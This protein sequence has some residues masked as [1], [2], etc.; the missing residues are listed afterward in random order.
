M[1]S[2]LP[3]VQGNAN[4]PSP[5]A[6]VLRGPSFSPA[7]TGPRC[8]Q[9]GCKSGRPLAGVWFLQPCTLICNKICYLVSP[10]PYQHFRL[11]CTFSRPNICVF[12]YVTLGELPFHCSRSNLKLLFPA[13]TVSPFLLH[14]FGA[15]SQL[16]V[17]FPDPI[18]IRFHL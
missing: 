7:C 9:A 4:L 12:N 8:N 18:S 17:V 1:S 5:L 13:R 6:S 10:H 2:C 14:P 3:S 15:V 16:S 11:Q